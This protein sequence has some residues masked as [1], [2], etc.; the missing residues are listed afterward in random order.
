MLINNIFDINK[1]SDN[2]IIMIN[3]SLGIICMCHHYLYLTI[4]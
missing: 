2:Y 3:P 4:I 1:S